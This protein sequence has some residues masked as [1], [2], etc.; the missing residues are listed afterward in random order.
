V[1]HLKGGTVTIRVIAACTNASGQPDFAFVNVECTA[2]RIEG[3]FHYDMARDQ[4]E[5]EGYEE[6][7][8]LFDEQDCQRFPWFEEGVCKH[9]GV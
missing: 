2:R 3:G 5:D 8:V 4:L 7:F 6:P 1:Q 9:L